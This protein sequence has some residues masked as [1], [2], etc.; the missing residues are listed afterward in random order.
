M[1]TILIAHSSIV[2][3]ESPD[4]D[5]YERYQLALNKKA[6]AHVRDW[7]DAVLFANYEVAT[8]ARDGHS[9]KRRG[10][11]KGERSLFTTERPAFTAKNRYAMP[12]KLPLDWTA[13]EEFLTQPQPQGE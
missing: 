11:G 1:S 6:D 13:V 5:T 4:T 7:A 8:V 12:D 3:F 2:R 9:D 10:V